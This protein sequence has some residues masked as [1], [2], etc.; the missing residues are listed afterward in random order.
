MRMVWR[1]VKFALALSFAEKEMRFDFKVIK[2]I[3]EIWEMARYDTWAI[4]PKA[5]L[6]SKS[7][8]M[9]VRTCIIGYIAIFFI[10][11]NTKIN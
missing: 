2:M 4:I 7:S 8:L 3:L 10:V 1:S 6:R 9:R 11:I 5:V